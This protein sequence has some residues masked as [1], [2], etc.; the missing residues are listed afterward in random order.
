METMRV[1]VWSDIA[2]PWCWV[3]KRRLEGALS[4]FAHADRVEVVWRA[5]E[6]D[7]SAPKVRDDGMSYAERLGRKYGTSTAQAEQ[8]IRRMTDTAAQDGIVMRFDRAQPGNTFDA[9]RLL[10][11]AHARGVQDALKER[12]FRAYLGEGEAIGDHPTLARLAGDVGL[13]VDEA[14]AVLATD[15]YTK[16]VRADEREAASLGVSGVPF[17]AL[18]GRYGVSGAQ[19]VDALLQVLDRAWEETM[20]DRRLEAVTP[21]E[22]AVCGPAGCS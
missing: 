22:G 20:E 3:G 10:H 13:D 16:E 9:H 6:L 18:A 5:F 11:L 19:P 8:M 21:D 12:L 14:T 2:C 15:T 17:F 7:P 4:R 1:E